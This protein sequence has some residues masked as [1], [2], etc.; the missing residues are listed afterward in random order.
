MIIRGGYRGKATGAVAPLR[1]KDPEL[2]Q[3]PYT[4]L[5]PGVLCSSERTRSEHVKML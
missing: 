4:E 5:C 3:A 1:Q 2:W